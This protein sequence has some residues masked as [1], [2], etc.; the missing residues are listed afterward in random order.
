MRIDVNGITLNVHVEG[1]GPPV[2]LLHGFPD[3]LRAW[4]HQIP[5]LVDAG[6]RVIAPDLRGFGESDAPAEVGAYALEHIIGDV[7]GLLDALEVD[8]VQVV[9]HDWGSMLGWI[10]AG[11]MPDRVDR[12]AT[13]Q[14][15]HPNNFFAGR[16]QSRQLSWYILFFQF[17][18]TAEDALMQSDWTMFREW[19]GDYADA[20]QAI[21]DF[22]RP[23]R[24]TAGLNWY[25]ANFD[26]A[27]F[28]ADAP[29]DLPP[30]ACDVL[31]LWSSGEKFVTGDQMLR[32]AAHVT[33]DWRLE[34]VEGAT[35]WV[36]LDEP[37][38]VNEQLLGFLEK[39]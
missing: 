13:L 22:S 23:G 16:E 12:Y 9:A 15:G 39:G 11:T 38:W 18:G 28:Q 4:R 26:P 33:G 6:Y 37:A 31:G 27:S 7:V 24:L 21:A 10:M 1:Q 3:G 34:R 29:F 2:L 17:A 14:I 30:V 32:S 35:H 5:A 19:M 25:R 20:E 36:Q 8:R